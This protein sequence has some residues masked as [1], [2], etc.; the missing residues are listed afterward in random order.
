MKLRLFVVRHFV[1]LGAAVSLSALAAPPQDAKVLRVVP[2]ADLKVLDPIWTPADVTRN[3]GF[4]VYDTLF[5]TDEAGEIKPQMVDT[6]K[7]SKDLKV[8]DFTLRPGLVFSDGQP[9]TSEDV[10][11]SLARWGKR[12]VL[13]QRMMA[14]LDKAQAVDARGFRLSFKE[15]FG[16]VLDALAK[17]GSNVPFIMPKRVAQT[18]ADKQI[19]DTTGSGPFTMKKDEY[20][21]GDRVVYLKNPRYVPRDEPASGTAGGKRV[22][23]DRV[24]WVILKDGQTQANALVNGEVDM[25]ELIPSEHFASLKANAKV[26]L[27]QVTPTGSIT[28]HYNHAVEPFDNP[29]IARAAMLAINQEAMLRS[30]AQF[31]ELYKTCVSIFPCGSLYA[32]TDAGFFTGK[33]QFDEAKKLLKEANYN[34]KPIVL[35]APTDLG[36]LVKYPQVYAQLLKQ[37][38]FNVDLQSMDWGTLVSRRVSKEPAGKGGWNIFITGW[39]GDALNPM[40]YGPLTGNG[41]SGYFGWPVDPEL[42]S[43]KAQFAATTD[44]AQR[45]RLAQKM[46]ARSFDAA[47][48]GPV[49][50][51]AVM[52]AMRK[53]AVTGVLKAPGLVYWNIRKN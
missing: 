2:M 14:V 49:G 6:F 45:K 53:G 1:A 22:N 17:T 25:L 24:E 9:V 30:Q 31:R 3:H 10:I 11:A 12:D 36:V 7:A 51:I 18:P 29:K 39:S 38:G 34:G 19:D 23:V 13:G 37:A 40:T 47:I 15:P 43:L 32:S 41:D 50:E 48:I 44:L 46:Q 4:M 16:L 52:S 28:A 8:W 21:P 5:G 20:R 33:P 42:E 27:M 26:E 35:L